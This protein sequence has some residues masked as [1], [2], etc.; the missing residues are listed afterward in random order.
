MNPITFLYTQAIYRPLLNSLVLIYAILPY[1]DLGLAI[2]I[3]TVVVRLL[4]HPTLVHTLRSQ[5]AMARLQPRLQE[6]Q[7]R[8][9]DN[10]EEQTRRTMELWKEHGVHPL[11]GCLPL[12]IQLPVLIGLYQVFWKGIALA[13]PALLY[14]FVPKVSSFHYVAFGLFDLTTRS[15]V[16]AVA[17]G[18]SQFLQSRFFPQVAT[19]S[20]GSGELNRAMRLQTTYFLPAFITVISWSLPAAIPLYWT[21]LNLLAIVQQLW[22]EKRLEH[23]EHLRTPHPNP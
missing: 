19:G 8:F 21:V 9:K 12:L 17:A 23:D 18:A 14:S 7:K 5:R 13:A 15:V 6:I 10:K 16:L 1:P 3:L 2:I 11:S 20:G 22:I 4:L